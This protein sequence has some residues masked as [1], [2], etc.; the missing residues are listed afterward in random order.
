MATLKLRDS[1]SCV[2][3]PRRR[4]CD[5]VDSGENRPCPREK[6]NRWHFH[7]RREREGG[8]GGGGGALP[9]SFNSPRTR[10]DSPAFRLPRN[11]CCN[12]TAQTLVGDETCH[13]SRDSSLLSILRP[14]DRGYVTNWEPEFEVGVVALNSPFRAAVTFLG[15]NYLELDTGFDFCSSLKVKGPYKRKIQQTNY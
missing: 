15:E 9:A 1:H 7:Q 13:A 12:D 10:F 11:V 3:T 8:S 4:V 5:G 14:F 6:K 2:I